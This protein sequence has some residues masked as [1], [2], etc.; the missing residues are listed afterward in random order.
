[1]EMLPTVKLLL[2][3][4][5]DDDTQDALLTLYID[6]VTR[7]VLTRTNRLELPAELEYLVAQM[8][9]GLYRENNAASGGSAPVSSVSEGGRSVSFAVA[10]TLELAA[11]DYLNRRN[12]Q[13]AAWRLLYR[14]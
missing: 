3:I 13:I 4:D 7:E 2:G 8:V 5:P 10:A 9:A 6:I 1:M 14:G 11:N 12:A